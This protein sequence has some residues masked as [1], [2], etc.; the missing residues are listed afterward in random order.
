MA[1]GATLLAV[2]AEV[3]HLYESQKYLHLVVA[4]VHGFQTQMK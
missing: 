3:Q 1:I 4:H 2:E